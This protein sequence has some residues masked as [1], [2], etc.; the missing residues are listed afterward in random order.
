MELVPQA[1]QDMAIPECG[2]APMSVRNL[3]V[4]A[5]LLSFGAVI[6]ALG[7]PWYVNVLLGALIGLALAELETWIV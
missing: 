3:S 1:T 2:P 7:L 5:V 4:I 6:V